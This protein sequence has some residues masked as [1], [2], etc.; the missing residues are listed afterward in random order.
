MGKKFEFSK[1]LTL[2]AVIIFALYGVWSGIEYYKLCKIAI[3]CGGQMPDAILAVTCV[4]TILGALLSYALYQFGLKNSRNKY[5]IDANG[6]PMV[7]KIVY[8]DENLDFPVQ[9]TFEDIPEEPVEEAE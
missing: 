7:E 8:T 6:E 4:T 2:F 5:R 3:T 9:D 1:F